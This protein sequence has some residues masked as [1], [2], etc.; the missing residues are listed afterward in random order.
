MIRKL[1]ASLRLSSLR[2]NKLQH[3]QDRENDIKKSPKTLAT[4]F[5]D[6]RRCSLVVVTTL[7]SLTLRVEA[8][9]LSETLIP[10]YQNKRRHISQS[11]N[12]Y[13]RQR[14]HSAFPTLL[15][16]YFLLIIA[17]CLENVQTCS[18]VSVYNFRTQRISLRKMFTELPL[19]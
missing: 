6:L 11:M 14:K 8:E 2:S 12:V 1:D 17:I 3:S 19:R 13:I 16:L 7:H 15:I 10:T 4:S 9:V 5:L 18:F